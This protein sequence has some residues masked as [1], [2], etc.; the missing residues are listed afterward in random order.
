MTSTQ[1]SIPAP[2]AEAV[3]LLF[4]H[5]DETRRLIEKELPVTVTLRDDT[6]IVAGPEDVVPKAAD[7]IGQFL[8][9]AKGSISGG[10]RWQLPTCD[11]CCSRSIR[12][13][14]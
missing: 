4:G 5:Q 9:V 7:L 1:I 6:L 8:S 12:A 13:A 11:A 3:R 2:D 10:R 14:T